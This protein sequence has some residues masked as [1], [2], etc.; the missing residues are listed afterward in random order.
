MGIV[1]GFIG[2]GDQQ[3]VYPAVEQGL[4]VYFWK[5]PEWADIYKRWL[6]VVG[7]VSKSYSP[8]AILRALNKN[9]YKWSLHTEYMIGQIQ[10]EHEKWLQEKE[11]MANSQPIEISEGDTFRENK[12]TKLME[13][14]LELD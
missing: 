7:K 8:E 2:Q 11:K 3:G 9:P 1:I 4:G 13:K 10:E 5:T 6:R 12:P 14:L